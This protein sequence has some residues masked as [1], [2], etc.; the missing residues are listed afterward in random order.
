M[1]SINLLD[2]DSWLSIIKDRPEVPELESGDSVGLQEFM[3]DTFE[4]NFSISLAS[5]GLVSDKSVAEKI[6]QN[7]SR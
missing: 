6:A 7:L 2:S 3:S 1:E 4:W 5:Q